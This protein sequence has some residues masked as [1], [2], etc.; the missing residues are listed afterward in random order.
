MHVRTMVCST[1]MVTVHQ[2]GW[3]LSPKEGGTG[4]HQEGGT[5]N[6]RVVPVPSGGWYLFGG[7]VG[8]WY[9][10]WVPLC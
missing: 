10:V 2:G 5:C 9:E 4:T 1:Y 3:Y 8:T 7:R 6:R